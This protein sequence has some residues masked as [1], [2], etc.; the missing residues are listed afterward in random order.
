VFLFV[1]VA[2]PMACVLWLTNQAARAEADAARESVM[3]AYKGQLR[4]LRDRAEALWTAR[5][6]ELDKR[7]GSGGSP[8][9]ARIVG[10]GLADSIV[11]L[12]ADGSPSYPTSF[13]SLEDPPRN[14]QLRD[15]Q[16]L[17]AQQNWRAAQAAYRVIAKTSRRPLSRLVLPRVR[18]ACF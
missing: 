9:F 14:P 8:D 10:S 5:L 6:A 13:A 1:G 7:A 11:Y 16:S 4:L 12:K 15:A 18:F 17:E 3:E 2:V